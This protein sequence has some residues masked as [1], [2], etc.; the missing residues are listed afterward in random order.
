MSIIS[1]EYNT[2][3]R[4]DPNSIRRKFDDRQIFLLFPLRGLFSNDVREIL[5]EGMKE[6]HTLTLE[7]NYFR[8]IQFKLL[9]DIVPT[10][11]YDL[12][13]RGASYW[14][15]YSLREIAAK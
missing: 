12:E 14:G 1:K 6:G 15:L 5:R 4:L 3:E 13:N 8:S 2:T 10:V 7:Y 11:Q 9:V